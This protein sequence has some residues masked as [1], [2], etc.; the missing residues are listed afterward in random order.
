MELR[1]KSITIRPVREEDLAYFHRWWNDPTLMREVL[2]ADFS[3][4]MDTLRRRYW[5]T[6]ANPGPGDQRMFVICLAGRPVGELA[7]ELA[8]APIPTAEVHVKIGEVALWRRGLGRDAL[9][10][11]I[12]GLFEH[13][14]V[15][16]VILEPGMHNRRMLALC[17]KL[18]LRET[19]TRT[20]GPETAV[21][22]EITRDDLAHVEDAWQSDAPLSC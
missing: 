22:F 13:L 11:F 12:R 4:D 19:G 10:T 20:D 17:R 21:R 8:D 14:P 7:Y 16:R 6:W 18:G 1:G 2:A 5:P 9:R 15:E 3:V